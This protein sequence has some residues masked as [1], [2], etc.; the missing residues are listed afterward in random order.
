MSRGKTDGFSYILYLVIKWE[1]S[2]KMGQSYYE[3]LS[4]HYEGF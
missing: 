3:Q 1:I 4:D 2:D